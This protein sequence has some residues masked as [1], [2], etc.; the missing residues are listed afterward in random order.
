MVI[1]TRYRILPK[2]KLIIEYYNGL[3]GVEDI[4]N[5][6]LRKNNDIEYD[7]SFNVIIDMRDAELD[8]DDNDIVEVSF[9]MQTNK[10]SYGERKSTFLTNTPNQVVSPMIYKSQ[11][12]SLPMKYEVFSTINASLTYVNIPRIH[13]K[14][15]EQIISDLRTEVIDTSA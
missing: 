12:K 15:I 8:L 11:I 13:K 14:Y 3:I 10:K 4:K 6:E 9:F 2:L 5:L 7:C 1:K